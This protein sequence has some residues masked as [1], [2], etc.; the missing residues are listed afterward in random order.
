[1]R[2][3]IIDDTAKTEIARVKTHAEAHHYTPGAWKVPGDDPRYVAKLGSYR[4]V[5]TI[6]HAGHDVF[7]HLSVSVPGNKYPNPAA[8]F[9]IAHEFGFTGWDE[10]VPGDPG[11]DW[12]VGPHKHDRCVVVAQDFPHGA[13]Q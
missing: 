12:V 2:A 11:P 7:R 3:L 13:L 4:V 1:M 8:V 9:L 5:F 6:T 10:K